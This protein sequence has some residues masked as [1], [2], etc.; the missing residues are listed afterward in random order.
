MLAGF[1]SRSSRY[2]YTLLGSNSPTATRKRLSFLVIGL[3]AAVCVG[4]V[5]VWTFVDFK[6]LSIWPPPSLDDAPPSYHDPPP[7][8]TSNHTESLPVDAESHEPPP[9][10]DPHAEDLP[11]LF[12]QY[13]EREL[14]LPQQDWNRAAPAEH[15]KYFNVPGFRIGMF[16]LVCAS[17]CGCSDL[18]WYRCWLG[19]RLSRTSPKRIFNV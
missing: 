15:E 17:P 10:I 14:R 2:R 11:P 1:I 13:H 5:V 7:L 18:A 3:I 8:D 12:S 4:S 9:L 16:M 19:K 6:A